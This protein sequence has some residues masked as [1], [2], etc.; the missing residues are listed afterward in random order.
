MA[1]TKI[2]S[3]SQTAR[4]RARQ[5]MG[6]ELDRARKLEG[7][8]VEVFS[9]ID[10]R[11]QAEIALGEALLEL[12]DLGVARSELADKTG[13]TAREVSSALRSAKNDVDSDDS[14]NESVSDNDQAG[15]AA[16]HEQ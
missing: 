11:E 5:A 1:A 12:R 14:S 15:G 13:L 7:K 4:A 16:P 3:R 2:D 9:A 6:D 8:L 10:A